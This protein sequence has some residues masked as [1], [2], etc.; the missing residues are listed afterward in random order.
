[1]KL[2]EPQKRALL[3]LADYTGAAPSSKTERIPEPRVHMA[4]AW[5]LVKLG[6]ARHNINDR[7]RLGMWSFAITPN[8]EEVA[9]SLR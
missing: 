9:R 7:T 1:M 3:V 5:C 8:G 6:L 2:T 4:A